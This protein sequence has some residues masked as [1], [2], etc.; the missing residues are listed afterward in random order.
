[1]RKADTYH[2]HVPM[3]RNLGALTSWN[4]VGLFRPVM[5]QLYLFN[6]LRFNIIPHLFLGF[7]NGIFTVGI[8]AFILYAF[9]IFLLL[10]ACQ[11]ILSSSISSF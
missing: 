3:S 9:L 6:F 8:P 4:P 5:G 10:A 11:P 7:S 1:V 2:P